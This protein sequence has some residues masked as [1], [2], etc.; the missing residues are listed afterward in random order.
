MN[1]LFVEDFLKPSN[2]G[3]ER[4]TYLISQELER[5]GQHCYIAF[6]KINDDYIPEERKLQYSLEESK[7]EL[8]DKFCNFV[9]QNDI[10]VVINQQEYGDKHYTIFCALKK[11]GNVRL[12]TF[13]HMS[14]ET[15]LRS[16]VDYYDIKKRIRRFL[17]KI[18][19]KGYTRW[20]HSR[21]RMYAL[22]DRYAVLSPGFINSFKKLYKLHNT[23]KFV[24]IPNALTF[25]K[26]YDDVEHKKKQVLFLAR[27]IDI[28]KNV[29]GALRIWK[30]IEEQGLEDWI[31][32]IGGDGQDNEMIREYASQLKLKRIKFLGAVEQPQQLY[33]DSQIFMMT[34]N[35][36]GFGLTL[37]EASQ[38]S[39]VPL[40]FDTFSTC[41]DIIHDGKDGFII[42]KGNEVL[43][44]QR[45][46][47]LMKDD[48][49][50]RQMQK[51]A[52]ENS[53]RFNIK[54]IVDLWEEKLLSD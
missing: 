7:E 48:N 15:Y 6:S 40:V 30:L 17:Q 37:T 34:S 16:Y 22:S 3:V 42:P 11:L 8:I 38:D 47:Q 41:H 36:E 5:R 13:D 1:I 23:G 35:F 21:R 31:F 20:E 33:R 4:V 10:S 45:V 12:I 25:R 46:I 19:Y 24:V 18:K 44:A 9:R 28:H 32:L 50:R 54:R 29:T 26:S 39:C 2:G 49:L 51:A 53:K 14:P 52:Y 27:F 43:Y